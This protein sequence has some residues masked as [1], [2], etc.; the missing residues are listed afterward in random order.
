MRRLLWLAPLLLIATL[1]YA[2]DGTPTSAPTRIT[3][4][5]TAAT[6]QALHVAAGGTWNV[7]KGALVTVETNNVRVAFGGTVPT[8]DNVGLILYV[9]D[10]YAMS[11]QEAATAQVVSA[12]SGAA[13]VIQVVTYK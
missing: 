4:T 5:N 9:G 12:S 6:L 7:T 2:V 13:G 3:T 11:P 8:V 10:A 1:A